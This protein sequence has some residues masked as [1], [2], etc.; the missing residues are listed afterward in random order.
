M[1]ANTHSDALVLLFLSSS[2]VLDEKLHDV[3]NVYLWNELFWLTEGLWYH[4]QV[5]RGY[6]LA[7]SETHIACSCS[8]GIVRVFLQ[9][10]LAYAATMPRPAPYGFH[11]L[12]DGNAGMVLAMGQRLQPGINFPDAVACQFL[13]EG[14]KLGESI[15]SIY[16]LFSFVKS[17]NP[18]VFG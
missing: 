2:F 9:L 15:Y 4:I 6:G 14:Q 18:P 5:R 10:S 12:T 3:K 8:D 13:H 11:G 1:I 7:V 16:V 17:P